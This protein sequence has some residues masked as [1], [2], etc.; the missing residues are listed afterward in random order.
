[1]KTKRHIM[2]LA[3]SFMALLLTG[4][5]ASCKD[6]KSTSSAETTIIDEQAA[7][8]EEEEVVMQEDPDAYFAEVKT[9]RVENALEML[10]ALKSNRH[11]IITETG[12]MNL[13]QELNELIDEGEIEPYYIGDGVKR[14]DG[15]VFYVNEYDGNTIVISKL[16]DVFI[17][18]EK[19]GGADLRVE[20]RYADVLRFENCRNIALRYLTMGHFEAGSC[21]GDVVVFE[22]TKNALVEDCHIFGCGV[23]GLSANNASNIVVND[24]HLYG[25]SDRAVN[26]DD[27]ENIAFNNCEIYDNDCGALYT[28]EGC[29]KVVFNNCHF[30]DNRGTLFYCNSE[31]KLK[32]CKVEHHY[33][34][35]DANVRFIN[36]ELQMDGSDE[37]Q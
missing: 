15:G 8:A 12:T 23:N 9:V 36:C 5:L 37:E 7:Q 22:R 24:S 21:S 18:G 34:G 35:N 25:C 1:M 26:L 29:D 27:T 16:H 3:G 6:G 31:V 11:I 32:Q 13:T 17:E 2:L 19:K 4:Q 10:R 33:G 20:P 30:Y 28:N 14:T